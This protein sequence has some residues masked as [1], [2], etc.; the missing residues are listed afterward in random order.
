MHVRLSNEYLGITAAYDG[1]KD[2]N[3]H[4]VKAL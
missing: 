4:R 1:M 3:L 2:G